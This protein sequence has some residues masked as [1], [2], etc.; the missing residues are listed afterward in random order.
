MS[1]QNR[2]DLLLVRCSNL[3][4]SLCVGVYLIHCDV[5][6]FH[7]PGLRVFYADLLFHRIGSVS[8]HDLSGSIFQGLPEGIVEGTLDAG[9]WVLLESDGVEVGVHVDAGASGGGHFEEVA[10]KVSGFIGGIEKVGGV[11]GLMDIADEV[12]QV[13]GHE[14]SLKGDAIDIMFE[15]RGAVVNDVDGIDVLL[16]GAHAVEGEVGVVYSACYPIHT[17]W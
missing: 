9:V 11:K 10:T 4:S 16:Q 17:C 5:I 8:R 12:Q 7:S 14:G 6:S 13:S 2:P 15:N 3:V 1:L